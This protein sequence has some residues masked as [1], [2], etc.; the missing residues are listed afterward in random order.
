ARVAHLPEVLLLEAADPIAP[1]VGGLEPERGGLVVG[2]VDRGV[3]LVLRQLPDGGQELPRPDD[4]LALPVVAE[5]PVAQHLEEGV[6]IGVA[7]DLLEVV[8]LAADAQHLLAV[9][10]ARV[11]PRL[12]TQK[13]LLELHHAGVGEEQA[14]VVRRHE[15]RA[16]DD[17]VTALAEV[18][19]KALPNL[20]AG[21]YRVSNGS[22]PGRQP[23]G[24]SSRRP[25]RAGALV[26]S[27]IS[28]SPKGAPVG[29]FMRARPTPCR[30]QSASCSRQCAG[31][32]QMAIA[33]MRSSLTAAA[34]C[35]RS[36]ASYSSRTRLALSS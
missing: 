1:D 2:G 10:R 24:G 4:G 36:P 15:R 34:A 8:V 6:M 5:R 17:G 19:E 32:P 27:S 18:V 23:E 3:K 14:G 22:V 16:R 28:A 30:R 29:R 21:H 7:A 20:V 31:G 25:Q 9:G 33:S 35:L 11:R 13:D 12:G 26:R